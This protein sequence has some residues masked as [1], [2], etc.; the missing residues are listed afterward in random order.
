[1]RRDSLSMHSGDTVVQSRT[2]GNSTTRSQ[3][4]GGHGAK[5]EKYHQNLQVNDDI[6]S[7]SSNLA[8]H[9]ILVHRC[10][11]GLNI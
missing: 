1:M 7:G 8:D 3:R 6:I 10:E 2:F 9:K 11:G 4:W 5:G